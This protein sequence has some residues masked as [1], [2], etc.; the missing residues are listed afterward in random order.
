MDNIPLTVYLS[1]IYRQYR[2][3]LNNSLEKE[4]INAAQVPILTYILK[5]ESTCQDEMAA[6]YKIDKGSIARS[7]RKLED[8]ELVYKEINPDNRRKYSLHLTDSGK[9]SAK[10]IWKI[11]EKWENIFYSKINISKEEIEQVVKQM[12]LAAININEME[13]NKIE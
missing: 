11:S 13:D 2:I 4:G 8:M 5:H 9:E 7:V 3:F 12:T 6:H 1:I 10:K